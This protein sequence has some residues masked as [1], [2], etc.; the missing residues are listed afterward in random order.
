MHI[1]E[2]LE[3]TE[4]MDQEDRLW[5]TIKDMWLPNDRVE[6]QTQEGFFQSPHLRSPYI[7]F[8]IP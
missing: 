1:S 3:L 2:D 4:P 7:F 6:I 5:V 8:H